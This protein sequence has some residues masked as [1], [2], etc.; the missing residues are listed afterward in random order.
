M[1]PDTDYYPIVIS[2]S[3]IKRIEE[4][5]PELPDKRE[6]RYIQIFK[7]PEAIAKIAKSLSISSRVPLFEELVKIGLDP[8]LIA[9]TLEQTMK[10]LEREKV[11]V[12]KLSDIMIKEIFQLLLEKKIAKEAIPSLLRHRAEHPKDKIGEALTALGLEAISEE[13]LKIIIDKELTKNLDLL[14][15]AGNR[16][17]G[18][19]IGFV[20]TDVRGKIDGKIVNECVKKQLSEKLEEIAA[21]KG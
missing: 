3:R 18:K 20:M 14:R 10:S 7:L 6:E 21:E 13:V 17:I 19:I 15:D 12:G 16:A 11:P 9:V 4:E 2:E 5:L 1:Y 8:T